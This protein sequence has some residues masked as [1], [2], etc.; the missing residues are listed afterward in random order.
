[1]A[2]GFTNRQNVRLLRLF[3]RKDEEQEDTDGNER[4]QT[5]LGV[6]KEERNCPEEGRV[7]PGQFGGGSWSMQA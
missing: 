5:C 2:F 1:V 7:G 6:K 4:M 3:Q